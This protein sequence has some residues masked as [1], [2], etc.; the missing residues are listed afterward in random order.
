MRSRCS[1]SHVLLDSS[2]LSL[3]G[4]SDALRFPQ[5]E[6]DAANVRAVQIQ[7][8]SN[9]GKQ[10]G[11]H[12][13]PEDVFVERGIFIGHK[14]EG[15]N[16]AL[17]HDCCNNGC[18]GVSSAKSHQNRLETVPQDW[19]TSVSL[20]MSSLR[21]SQAGMAAKLNVTQQAVNNWLKGK[22]EPSAEMYYRMAR[23]NLAAPEAEPL[24]ARARAIS[25]G[26]LPPPDMSGH[27]PRQRS[28]P[29]GAVLIPLLKRGAALSSKIEDEDIE[30]HLPFPTLFCGRAVG[31]VVCFRATDDA[32]EPIIEP[33]CIVAI[34]CGQSDAGLL[35][36]EMVAAFDPDGKLTVRWL[37]RSGT[38]AYLSTHNVTRENPPIMLGS[39]G[40]SI[41]GWWVA[42]KVI[43]WV[44]MAL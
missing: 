4:G 36:N 18:V 37:R 13:S 14:S 16:M 15:H 25:K 34:D 22:R 7:L 29:Q 21:L 20:F 1:A 11:L 3:D 27:G 12:R 33:G 40:K 2:E 5:A 8:L 10:S 32:M 43:W 28:A 39:N 35:R 6:R 41:D 30:D 42:G 38:T 9:A 31:K 26:Q 24:I 17:I 44:G 19:A 23:L